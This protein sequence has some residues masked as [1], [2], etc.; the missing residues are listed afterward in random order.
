M[1]FP[2]RNGLRAALLAAGLMLALGGCAEEPPVTSY[3]VPK[4][5]PEELRDAM[6][7]AARPPAGDRSVAPPMT[8]NGPATPPEF[9]VPE[10]WTPSRGTPFSVA[11]FQVG[12]GNHTAEI[13]LSP[14]MGS[15]EANI[16]R[17]RGQVGLESQSATEMAAEIEQV[18]VGDARGLYVEAFGPERD[19]KQP[20]I[21]AIIA[22]AGGRQWIFKFTGDR[23]LAGQEKDRFREFAKSMRFEASEVSGDGK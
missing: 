12:D 7:S 22:Q 10:G 6:R 15:I 9:D 16:N 23:E 21:L 5:P 19:G 13:T 2:R 14:V 17:W 4:Q 18:P 11:A 20:A 1:R 3:T 8:G